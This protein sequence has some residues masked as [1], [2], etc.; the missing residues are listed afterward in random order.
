MYCKIKILGY[1][2]SNDY[3]AFDV[4]GRIGN[5]KKE[6]L[7][8]GVVNFQSTTVWVK[9]NARIP[10]CKEKVLSALSKH[11]LDEK[12]KFSPQL[13]HYFKYCKY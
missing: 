13:H 8:S 4:V 1:S 10:D 6:Y 7:G 2:K 11:D 5:K 3:A 12:V 9:L